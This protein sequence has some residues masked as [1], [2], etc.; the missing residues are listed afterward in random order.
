MTNVP[1]QSLA[2][3]NDAFVKQQAQLLADR[4]ASLREP[5]S[6]V[7]ALYQLALSRPASELEIAQALAFLR[8]Q[9][10]AR[11]SAASG[12]V[13]GPGRPDAADPVWSDLAHAI[14]NLKEFLYF[15]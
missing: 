3:L 9:A 10:A 12:D 13:A 4:T 8:T 5:E 2:L 6:R 1:A 7:A 11:N 14:F 15:H